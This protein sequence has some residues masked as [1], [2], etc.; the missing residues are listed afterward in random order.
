[1]KIIS[2][3][4]ILLLASFFVISGF[5]SSSSSVLNPIAIA[6]SSFISRFAFVEMMS[7]LFIDPI[8]AF[9]T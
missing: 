4:R 6:S 2:I 3:S 5:A 7:D 9:T 1:M 8:P